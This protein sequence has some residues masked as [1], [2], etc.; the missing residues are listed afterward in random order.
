MIHNKICEKIPTTI[1]RSMFSLTNS[2]SKSRQDIHISTTNSSEEKRFRPHVPYIKMFI[3]ERLALFIFYFLGE[4]N[5]RVLTCKDWRNFA[6][7]FDSDICIWN[8][9]NK[10]VQKNTK[11]ILN[12]CNCA[13]VTQYCNLCQRENLQSSSKNADHLYKKLAVALKTTKY[14]RTFL[15]SMVLETQSLFDLIEGVYNILGR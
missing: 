9:Y 11:Q 15:H 4:K 2:S 13:R 6:Q 10:H 14:W 5:E 1:V 8:R 3:L 12:Y 7:R